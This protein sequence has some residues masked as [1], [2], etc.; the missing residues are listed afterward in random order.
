M[1][2]LWVK[3]VNAVMKVDTGCFGSS[4]QGCWKQAFREDLPG[5][6][7]WVWLEGRFARMLR[8]HPDG[9]DPDTGKNW[10]QEEKGTTED[11]M[12]GWHHQLN[13]HEFEQTPGHGEGQG[14]LVCCSPWGRK[15]MDTTERLNKH[16]GNTSFPTPPLVRCLEILGV[17]QQARKSRR[18]SDIIST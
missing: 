5:R 18:Q 16:K 14:S 17:Y 7:V 3:V 11:E 8:K 10:G 15:E 9:K 6:T 2:H 4:G 1:K 13:G 12:A